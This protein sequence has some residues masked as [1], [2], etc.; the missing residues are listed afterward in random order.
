M[1]NPLGQLRKVE[2]GIRKVENISKRGK[3]LISN[4]K[5]AQNMKEADKIPIEEESGRKAESAFITSFVSRK[6]EQGINCDFFGY[7]ELNDFGCWVVADGFD[8]EGFGD[9]AAKMV[10]ESILSQFIE[11]PTFSRGFLKKIILRAHKN[12]KEVKGKNRKKRGMSASIVVFITN[13]ASCVFANVGN[14]RIYFI[15]D[16]IVKKKSRDNSIAHLMYEMHQLDYKEIRFHSQRDKLTQSIGDVDKI[17]VEVSPTI[18]LSDGD[19]IMLM[20]HGAWENLDETEIEVEL[21]KSESVGKWIG[22]LENK[23]KSNCE[24]KLPNYTI[25]G[26]FINEIAQS[27]QTTKKRNYLKYFFI[28]LL[29][30][31]ILLVLFVLYMYKR[32]RDKK[33]E[34]AFKHEEVGLK[35]IEDGKLDQALAEFDMSKSEYEKLKLDNSNSNFVERFIFSSKITNTNLGKQINSVDDK[36][37]QL[38]LLEETLQMI[39]EADKAFNNND[40]ASA[41]TIYSNARNQINNVKGIKYDKIKDVSEKLDNSIIESSALELGYKQKLE[42]D[43]SVKNSEI[44]NAIRGYL[45]SKIIFLKYNRVDLIAEVTEKADLLVKV[46]DKKFNEAFMYERKSYEVEATDINSAIIYTEMA[47]NIYNELKDQI[48]VQE[49]TDRIAMLTEMKKSLTLESKEYLNEAR[50]YAEN[51]EYDRAMESVKKSKD[52]STKLKDDQK[53]ADSL[54]RE[55]DLLSD[56]DKYQMAKEKYEE[57]YSVSSNTNNT[58]QQDYLKG[59]IDATQKAIDTKKLETNAD[60]LF[61]DKKYKE[62]RNIYKESISKIEPLKDSNYFDRGK[63]NKILEELKAKEKKAWKKSNWIPFF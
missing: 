8:E 12:L 41:V 53:M 27:G 23:I 57:A 9:D 16:E 15:R 46:R 17:E 7:V 19:R 55:A 33:Y 51:G 35:S 3:N 59:K 47:R 42:A 62:A 50:T 11:K 28:F 54:Q 36:I 2:T 14:A 58:V 60:T 13:Y 18:P 20:S 45:G 22:K 44:E 31:G 37:V 4:K 10:S 40:F 63:F 34:V 24:T 6:G 29:I 26:I 38:G 52:L 56:G 48:K 25:T 32:G 39:K 1:A 43:E 30:L 61:A 21:S 5:N 49:T